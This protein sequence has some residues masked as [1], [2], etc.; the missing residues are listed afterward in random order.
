METEITG[1]HNERNNQ[2]ML[3]ATGLVAED[4]WF[5]TPTEST[6]LNWLPKIARVITS[7]AVTPVSNLVQNRPRGSY[8]QN[9][10]N[11]TQKF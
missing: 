11:I 4:Y 3:T 6:S 5:L 1:V 10:W 2:S 9:G 7:A 8:G